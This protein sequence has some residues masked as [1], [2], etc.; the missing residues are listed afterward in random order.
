MFVWNVYIILE[1]VALIKGNK[2]NV[3]YFTILYI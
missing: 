2:I 3:I 1:S